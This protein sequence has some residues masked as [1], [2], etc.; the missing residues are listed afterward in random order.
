MDSIFLNL[1]KKKS[2][3]TIILLILAL[4]NGLDFNEFE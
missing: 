3:S 1:E 4:K 2:V